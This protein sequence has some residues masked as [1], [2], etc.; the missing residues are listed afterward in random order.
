MTRKSP[1]AKRIVKLEVENC[2]CFEMHKQKKALVK[3]LENNSD[4]ICWGIVNLFDYIDDKYYY[5]DTPEK[6]EY[7]DA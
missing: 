5:M 1:K 3:L 7:T 2:D 6:L 4:N